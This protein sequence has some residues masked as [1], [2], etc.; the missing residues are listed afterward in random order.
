M[1]TDKLQSV[2]I[3]QPGMCVWQIGPAHNREGA[4]PQQLMPLIMGL[5]LGISNQ[6]SYSIDLLIDHSM[7]PD[8]IL[9]YVLV[10]PS[11]TTRLYHDVVRP[12]MDIQ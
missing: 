11:N 8:V 5:G 10:T 3:M 6:T 9:N 7:I 12:F 1:Y 2:R 4:G